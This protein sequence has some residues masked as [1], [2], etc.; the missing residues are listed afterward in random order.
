MSPIT[1]EYDVA[2]DTVPWFGTDTDIRDWF[3]VT[4][5][6]VEWFAPVSDLA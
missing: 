5:D 4:L 3:M 2:L 6:I 1:V